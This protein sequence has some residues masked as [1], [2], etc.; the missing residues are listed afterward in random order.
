MKRK[1]LYEYIREEIINELSLNEATPEELKLKQ[2]TIANRTADIAELNKQISLEKDPKKQTEL[3]ARLTV[4][5]TEL[6]QAQAIK[7]SELEE[8]ASYKFYR[9]ANR[10]KFDALKDI[11]AGTI[12]ARVLDAI[13]AA[14][15][16]GL[17][18]DGVAKQLGIEAALVN[19]ILKKFSAANALTLPVSEKPGKV[20]AAEPEVEE[21]ETE[22]PETEKPESEFFMAGD[23]DEEEKGM[24]PIDEPAEPSASD[25][26]A[27]EKELGAVDTSKIEA[28]NKAAN[29]VKSLTAKIE[30]MKKGPEREKKMVA[31]KQYIKNNRSTVLKGYKISDL[32]NG[33]IS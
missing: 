4:L 2:T 10:E 27:A 16:Q 17:T 9:I 7:E 14:G 28:A 5:K 12:D 8:M 21:P 25:I 32:T 19:P 1:E 11:Y 13:E 18:Q 23:E 3:K 26:A 20:K 6:A 33:L 22:E 29:I 31:L 24:E 30:G 15:E